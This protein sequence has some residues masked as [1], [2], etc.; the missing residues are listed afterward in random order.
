MSNKTIIAGKKPCGAK[1]LPPTA[2]KLN[3]VSEM[4]SVLY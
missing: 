4:Q 1:V 2:E 3:D